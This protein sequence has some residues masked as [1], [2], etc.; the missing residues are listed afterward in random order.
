MAVK[1]GAQFRRT[2]HTHTHTHARTH[3]RTHAHTHTHT[4]THT[5]HTHTHAHTHTHKPT[6]IVTT[7]NK[8][9]ILTE[10]PN[11]ACRRKCLHIVF[12]VMPTCAFHTFPFF[13]KQAKSS[14][15]LTSCQPANHCAAAVPR[16]WLHN[17]AV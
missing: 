8:Q 1:R 16:I 15:T 5:Q 2:K 3:A 11:E 7:L 14:D 17:T 9:K 12:V 10:Q 4:H 6:S 13:T